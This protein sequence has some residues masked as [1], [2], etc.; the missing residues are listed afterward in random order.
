MSPSPMN[1][2]MNDFSS[3]LKNTPSEDTVNRLVRH[4]S[5]QD[6]TTS[7]MA[8]CSLL[9]IENARRFHAEARYEELR[10]ELERKDAQI[11]KISEKH[12]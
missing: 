11:Q 1:A 6:R 5:V 7:M 8:L 4:A 3:I 10:L 2:L 12:D 9:M